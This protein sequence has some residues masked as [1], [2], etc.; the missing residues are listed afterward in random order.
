[1]Q[2]EDKKISLIGFVCIRVFGLFTVSRLFLRDGPSWIS[3][4]R[5][6]F[7]R[8]IYDDHA[9]YRLSTM[10]VRPVTSWLLSSSQTG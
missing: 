5:E 3:A 9:S 6:P 4:H 8:P 1:L 7:D 2:A 10:P